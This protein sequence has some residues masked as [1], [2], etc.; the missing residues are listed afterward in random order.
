MNPEVLQLSQL[1]H[2]HGGEEIY[3][4][5]MKR[6]TDFF[7]Y[8]RNN[9]IIKTFDNCSFN[10]FPYNITHIFRIELML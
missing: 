5:K 4:P 3:F 9:V 7:S 2:H 6:I 10:I 1:D 8:F